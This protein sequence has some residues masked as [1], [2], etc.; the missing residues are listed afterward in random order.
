ME[1]LEGSWVYGTWAEL[2]IVEEEVLEISYRSKSIL[3]N[4]ADGVL[5]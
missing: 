4:A 3:R 5:L 1:Y 2:V